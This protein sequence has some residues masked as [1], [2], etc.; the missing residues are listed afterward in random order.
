VKPRADRRRTQNRALSWLVTVRRGWLLFISLVVYLGLIAIF[1]LAYGVT[2]GLHENGQAT[3]G[4]AAPVFFSLITQATVGYG[5]IVPFTGG[6][7]VLVALQVVIGVSFIALVPAIIVLR[8]FSPPKDAVA[9]SCRAIFDPEARQF[10]FRLVNDSALPVSIN[11]WLRLPKRI[12][13]TN[14]P[15]VSWVNFFRARLQ[16]SELNIVKTHVPILL[17]S[18]PCEPEPVPLDSE[19]NEIELHPAHLGETRKLSLRLELIYPLSGSYMVEH[20]Y[21]HANIVCGTFPNVTGEN[22][23]KHWEL[24]NAVDEYP[25][26]MITE[27]EQ[28]PCQTTC[29]FRH[30]CSLVNREH[31]LTQDANGG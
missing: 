13:H 25:K 1:A 17:R 4:A 20:T 26:R 11:S 30:G 27:N 31:S 14:S 15:N 10:R 16:N 19:H 9:F 2:G 18:V 29:V 28:N 21:E 12:S 7:R 3:K 22:G 24:L 6:A 23:E 8:I 5:D